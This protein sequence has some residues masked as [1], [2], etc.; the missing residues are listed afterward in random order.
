MPYSLR[1]LAA[2]APCALSLPA[3]ADSPCPQ[4]LAELPNPAGV[5]DDYFG[6]SLAFAG[7]SLMVGAWAADP[8]G[9]FSGAVYEFADQGQG[10]QL[11]TT[12][13]PLDTHAEQR[14]G[15]SLAVDPDQPDTL[16]VGAPWDAEVGEEAG[17][18][19]I[20]ERGVDGTWTQQAKLTGQA[21]PPGS[22][23]GM[24]TAID[25][26]TAVV[27]APFENLPLASVGGR[28]YVFERDAAGD[29]TEVTTLFPHIA[30]DGQFFGRSIALDADTLVVGAPFIGPEFF[31]GIVIVYRRQ[32]GQWVEQQTLTGTLFGG[33]NRFGWAVVQMP[34]RILVGA[35][36]DSVPPL[37]Y[38]N[39][40]EPTGPGGSWVA[41]DTVLADQPT[42]GDR[43]GAALASEGQ[44]LVVG[45]WNY[46][47]TGRAFLYELQDDALSL[48]CSFQA[49]GLED[50]DEFGVE[51]AMKWPL[52]AVGAME[53]E[54]AAGAVYLFAAPL[55][56]GDINGDG[57]VDLVDRDLLVNVLLGVDVDLGHIARSDIN[58]DGS[59]DGRDILAFVLALLGA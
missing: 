38:F 7:S 49:P 22:Y 19:Y 59:A 36:R 43:F 57:S 42:T 44:R 15:W 29:W 25:G 46:G 14:F 56:P 54:D 40:F 32:A 6:A 33:R 45:A 41:V 13:L 3:R 10:W 28:A 31:D 24:E 2:L 58:G 30:Y 8:G 37:G 4:L 12:I 51:V 48:D 39:P 55:E 1:L 35:P 5:P 34:G 9:T 16:I 52:V 20:F 53:H 21:T 47:L 18:A 11:V 23:F 50:Y 27:G 17:A 26:E